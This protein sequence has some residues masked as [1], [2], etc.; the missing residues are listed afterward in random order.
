MLLLLPRFSH[1]DQLVPCPLPDRVG[2]QFGICGPGVPASRGNTAKIV[3]LPNP[4]RPPTPGPNPRPPPI[5]PRPPVPTPPP[6]P[7]YSAA[8]PEEY[9]AWHLSTLVSKIA[10]NWIALGAPVLL[11]PPPRPPTPGPR[12]VPGPLY[13]RPDQPTPPPSPRRNTRYSDPD[14]N[15]AEVPFKIGHVSRSLSPVS[16]RVIPVFQPASHRLRAAQANV[17]TQPPKTN[18]PSTLYNPYTTYNKLTDPSDSIRRHPALPTRAYVM[19]P[20]EDDPHPAISHLSPHSATPLRGA[21]YG[22]SIRNEVP[23][24]FPSVPLELPSDED[25]NP[26]DALQGVLEATVSASP[27]S[28]REGSN[29]T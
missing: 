7:R 9:V 28:T 26:V 29:R 5:P 12:S 25:T 18:K 20:K 23:G 4:P 10:V 3:S 15:G 17:T 19:A 8:C 21:D 27:R 24:P 16:G 22:A 6:S 11:P 1:K 13:P 2:T 14:L